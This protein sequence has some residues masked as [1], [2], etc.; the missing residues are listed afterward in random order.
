MSSTKRFIPPGF[1]SLACACAILLAAALIHER[2][3]RGASRP[4]T[5]LSGTRI[6]YASWNRMAPP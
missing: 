6:A 2:A 1:R 3:L 5:S 4:R